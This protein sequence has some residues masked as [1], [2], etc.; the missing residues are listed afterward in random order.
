METATN[1]ILCITGMHRSGTSLIASW[2][3]S[4]GLPTHDGCFVKPDLGNPKGYFEDSDFE[5]IQIETIQAQIPDSFG[6]RVFSDKSLQFRGI[7]AEEAKDL[8]KRRN[9]KY[10]QWG[11]K[12]PRTLLF[13]HQ[14]KELI[15]RLKVL[16]IWRSC[17]EVVESLL[18]RSKSAKQNDKSLTPLFS[19]KVE[20]AVK[21]WVSYNR[22]LCQY[23]EQFDGDT[24]LVPLH[25][26]LHQ[27]RTFIRLLKHKLGIDLVFEPISHVFDPHLLHRSSFSFTQCVSK[28]YGFLKGSPEIE[29]NLTHLSDR[30]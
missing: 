15:P 20:E 13:L 22:I 21:L 10:A 12:D 27:D 14:W 29:K 5:K 23:K 7:H 3:E 18:R 8:I 16:L 2:L 24:I 1:S 26:V 9:K 11:W 6:W 30:N 19:I 25:Y 4:C 17:G 28:A